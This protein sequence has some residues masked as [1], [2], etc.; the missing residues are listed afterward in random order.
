MRNGPHNR[1]GD[2]A[3]HAGGNRQACGRTGRARRI[4]SRT[5]FRSV[6]TPMR[7]NSASSWRPGR[8]SRSTTVSI[9]CPFHPARPDAL[10]PRP[11]SVVR[12]CPA[13]IYG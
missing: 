11:A 5:E 10:F 8:S 9:Q 13:D 1:P 4:V 6:A 7:R 3:A 2:P 12:E